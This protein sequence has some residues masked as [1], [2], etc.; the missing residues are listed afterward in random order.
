MLTYQDRCFLRAILTV[1]SFS[2]LNNNMPRRGI[3]W[4]SI[5]YYTRHLPRC[6]FE[7][8]R[9]QRSR[10]T[11]RG[12]MPLVPL[13]RL[14]MMLIWRLQVAQEAQSLSARLQS[15]APS[16][17]CMA[18]GEIAGPDNGLYTLNSA[19]RFI[20]AR[21]LIKA[22]IVRCSARILRPW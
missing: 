22:I 21:R 12:Y 18:D 5:T 13:A 14:A 3:S 20:P 19:G 6:V 16:T 11:L 17:Y 10:W 15:C 8:S 9:A 4:H 2:Q 7:V 1:L